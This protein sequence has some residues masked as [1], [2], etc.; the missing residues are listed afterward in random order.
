MRRIMAVIISIAL[1]LTLSSSV[2]ADRYNEYMEIR[3]GLIFGTDDINEIRLTSKGGFNICEGESNDYSYRFSM[4][5]DELIFTKNGITDFEINENFYIAENGEVAIKPAYGIIGVNGKEYRG[6]ICLKR[7]E[8]SD[9]TVVNIVGLEE[10][11]FSVVGAEM[12]P[13]W[14]IEALKAQAVSSLD[15]CPSCRAGVGQ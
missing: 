15:L 12:S 4:L 8:D 6:F 11:L 13:S 1:L 10:Y 14:N 2:L 5:E 9:I 3:I 7:I